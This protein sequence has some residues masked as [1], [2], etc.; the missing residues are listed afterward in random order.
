MAG[1]VDVRDGVADDSAL[2]TQLTFAR[3]SHAPVSMHL[4]PTRRLQ[5]HVVPPPTRSRAHLELHRLCKRSAFSHLNE[6]RRNRR[7]ALT[8]AQSVCN[9]VLTGTSPQLAV[10][11]AIS[12]S[13]ARAIRKL[14]YPNPPAVC[15]SALALIVQHPLM[16]HA[17][18]QSS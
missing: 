1:N 18:Y 12:H 5:R 3:D 4:A 13:S 2:L 16:V 15:S 17:R 9:S 7:Q 14:R 11:K 8:L 6:P 10:S